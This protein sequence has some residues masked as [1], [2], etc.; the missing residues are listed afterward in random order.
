MCI[1]G[2]VRVNCVA[3]A[4]AYRLSVVSG[5]DIA[6]NIYLVVGV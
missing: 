1:F 6:L 4:P 5:T 2:G 3:G